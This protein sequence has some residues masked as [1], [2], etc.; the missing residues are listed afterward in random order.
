VRIK[1]LMKNLLKICPEG[2]LVM[3]G[4]EVS[5]GEEAPAL[6]ETGADEDE[7]WVGEIVSE[8]VISK[9]TDEQGS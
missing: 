6:D 1:T 2:D 5:T 8:E 7:V 4:E 3:V 9:Y